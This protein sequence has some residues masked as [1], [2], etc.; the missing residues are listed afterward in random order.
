[1]FKLCY[2]QIFRMFLYKV[3]NSRWLHLFLLLPELNF[4][5][6]FC[7]CYHLQ[8]IFSLSLNVEAILTMLTRGLISGLATFKRPH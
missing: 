5:Q 8:Y 3:Q 1:M 7:Y 2:V 6:M 4:Y